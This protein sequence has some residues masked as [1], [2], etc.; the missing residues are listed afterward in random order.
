MSKKID[1]LEIILKVTERCNIACRYCYY[2]EGDNRDFTDKPGVMSKKTV[3]QLA[4]YLKETVAAHQ[5]D[6]LR[7]DIHGGEP[8]MMGKKRLEEM[9]LILSEA[10]KKICTLEFVLQCNGTLIDDDWI[11]IFAKYQVAASVSLDG[12]AITHNLNRIDR[13]G[14]GTYH[15]VMAGLSQLI[16]ASKDNKLP[17]PGIIC[18]INPDKNGKRIF[19]YFVDEIKTPYISFIEPDFTIDEM[20]EKRVE[21]IGNF[22]LDVYQEWEKNNTPKINRHMSLRVFND[23]LSILMISGTEYEKIKKVNYVVITVRSDGYINPDDILRNT[24]PELF[25]QNY[26]LANSTLEEFITSEAILGLYRG[27]F[28]LPE[29]CQACGVRKLCRNGFCFG[30]LP[31]RYSKE[32]GM[33]NINLFCK[34]YQDNLHQIM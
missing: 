22:L 15:R 26:N 13:R 11:N 5:I 14:K 33:N 7:I 2:F 17:Y 28:T 1:I 16:A 19:R 31:H 25:N 10:L 20:N 21:G 32:N 29:Q 27:I 3:I 6:I 30:S 34:F 4:N 9:L 18:V 12:D 23:L 24:H 8:L